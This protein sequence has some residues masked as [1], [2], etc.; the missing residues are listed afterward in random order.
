MT[1]LRFR[2]LP[3]IAR[4]ATAATFFIAWV[5]FAEFVVDRHG[6]DRFLPYYR[7]GDLCPY[8]LAIIALIT[9]VWAVAHRR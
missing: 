8:D 6:L 7:V 4:V 9:I 1:Q 3:L 5:L 2:D